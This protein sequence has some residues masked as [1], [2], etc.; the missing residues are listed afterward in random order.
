MPR[1]NGMGPPS[2]G[3]GGGGGGRGG[4]GRGRMGGAYKA[5]PQGECVCT[6]CGETVPHIPGQ[7]CSQIVCPKCGAPMTRNQ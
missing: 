1:G 7:P 4:G 5:G 3:T 6:S 2:G